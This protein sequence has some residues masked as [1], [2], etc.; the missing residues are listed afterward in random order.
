MSI[1]TLRYMGDPV[2]REKTRPIETLDGGYA[3]IFDDMVETM[4]HN[5]GIGLAAPQVGIGE[6]FFVLDRDPEGWYGKGGII[7]FNPVILEAHGEVM[8]EEG[9]LSIPEIRDEVRRSAKVVLGGLDI[10]GNEIEIEAEGLRARAL[11]HEIDHLDG[12]LF[13][14]RLGPLKRGLHARKWRKIR[15]ELEEAGSG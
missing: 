10:D 14:D 11:Q 6:R 9:C 4:Y 7:V 15:R 5:R 12:I 1:L 3:E 13:L 8:M 2:L